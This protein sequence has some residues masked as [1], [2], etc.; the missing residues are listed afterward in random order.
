MAA[1]E[2]GERTEQPTPRRREEARQEGQVARSADFTAAVVLLGGLLLLNGFGPEMF[3]RMLELVRESIDVSTTDRDGVIPAIARAAYAALLMLAP[4]MLALLIIVA[5]GGLLQTGGSLAW[6]RLMPK[7]SNASPARGLKQLFS[8]DSIARLAMGLFKIWLIGWVSWHAI[9]TDLRRLLSMS[10]L[11][12]LGAFMNASSL[13]FTLGVRIG[14]LLLTLG[15]ADYFYQRWKVEQSLKMSKQ[16]I[17]DEMKRMEGDPLIKQ[18]R[19]QIQ[20]KL[21]MQRLQVDVPRADV[22]VTNPT[23]YAVALKYDQLTMSAPRVVAKGKDMLAMRI[24]QIAQQA[25]VPIVQRPPL[26]RGLYASVDV[27]QEAPAEF[28]RAIAEVLAY[29]YQLSQRAAG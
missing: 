14:L 8:K 4:F 2:S 1:D 3:R 20:A 7:L 29:V 24:R 19:R 18:R 5:G 15:I 9:S 26:A 6:K 13:M 10:G 23:E 17:R 16:D 25:G 27:G 22:V 11:D 21:A 12:V 28:Y